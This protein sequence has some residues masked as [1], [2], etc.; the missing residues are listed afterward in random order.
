M[1]RSLPSLHE[2]RGRLAFEARL[3]WA[4]VK[5]LAHRTVQ[6]FG[7][8]RC[9]QIAASIS[10]YVFFSVFPL[11]IFLVTIFGQVLRNESVK[12]RSSTR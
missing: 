10:Y 9:T 12:A 5:V 7:D 6:E 11:T 4:D 8:D 3:Y 1:V 2:L